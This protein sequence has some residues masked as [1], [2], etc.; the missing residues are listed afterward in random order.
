ML[1]WP[2]ENTNL[3]ITGMMQ[4]L[5]KKF[6]EL[7]KGCH[8]AYGKYPNP[9]HRDPT[10]EGKIKASDGIATIKK[11][12]GPK[13]WQEH[14]EGKMGLGIIPIVKGTNDCY[15]FAADIDEYAALSPVS[16]VK[17]IRE[18]NMPFVAIR[19]KSGGLHLTCFLKESIPSSLAQKKANEMVA[20]LGFGG[21]E[22]FPKQTDLG[23][24]PNN[25]GQWLNMPYFGLPNTLRY[26]YDNEGRAITDPNAFL[27][28]A[29][30]FK[31]T[32][33]DILNLNYTIDNSDTPIVD[34][35]PC[36]QCLHKEGLPQGSRN[37]GLYNFGV[38]FKKSQPDKWEELLEKYNH[39]INEPV[40]SSELQDIIRSLKK[41][42]YN[43][44]CREHPIKARCNMALCR[45]RKFGIGGGA[46][47][48][49][50]SL[51]MLQTEPVIWYV[52]IEE[53]GIVKV[54]TKDL[55]DQ[56]A[57]KRACMEQ[58][59]HIPN[60]VK[61]HIWDEMLND[62]MEPSRLHII[63]MPKESTLVGAVHQE[64]NRL[65][66]GKAQARTKEE[67]LLG[68][69]WLDKETGY[70]YTRLS[71]IERHLATQ[72]NLKIKGHHLQRALKELN[73]EHRKWRIKG[74]VNNYWG[75]HESLFAEQNEEFDVPNVSTKV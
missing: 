73:P 70:K 38:F 16:V 33:D 60:R 31:V 40:T 24:D 39:S 47:A 37:N 50:K 15:W 3:R 56:I 8:T 13:Q 5:A 64:L 54:E 63:K 17:K 10:Q 65:M 69:P 72:T 49:I 66:S 2:L 55:S 71:D 74:T 21:C 27:D 9:I 7:Y 52:E 46:G 43:Y 28:Y 45:K 26:A 36:L 53:K 30:K 19:S 41:K 22:I 4:E 14:L 34:G 48:N 61:E 6:L 59:K 42:D 20:H 1:Q 57:F 11:P 75:F 51:S 62:L 67:L 29:E 68:K 44:K 58:I 18:V 32:L 35:P 25:F 23:D 12:V